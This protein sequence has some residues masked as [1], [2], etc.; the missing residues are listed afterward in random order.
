MM[1]IFGVFYLVFFDKF[2]SKLW[3]GILVGLIGFGIVV[4]GFKDGVFWGFFE[5]VVFY[6]YYGLIGFILMI[7]FLVIVLEIYKDKGYK[8]C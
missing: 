4:L 5:W 3:G 2:C 7:F 6:F 1:F 8:G